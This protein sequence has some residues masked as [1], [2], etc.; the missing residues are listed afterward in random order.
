MAEPASK[1]KKLKQ[2]EETLNSPD[3]KKRQKL[4]AI[5]GVGRL[6]NV[7]RAKKNLTLSALRNIINPGQPKEVY[8]SALRV[9]LKLEAKGS[10]RETQLNFYE[11]ILITSGL[12]YNE[13]IGHKYSTGEPA[14]TKR[15]REFALKGLAKLGDVE[16]TF[17]RKKI[18]G[19]M[20]IIINYATPDEEMHM[21]M[22]RL[23][24]K[25]SPVNATNKEDFIKFY[26][27][28][29]TDSSYSLKARKLAIEGLEKL[30]EAE[31]LKSAS[32][33]KALDPPLRNAARK[34]LLSLLKKIPS[35]STAGLITPKKLRT[36]KRP[37][38]VA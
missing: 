13:E 17:G 6:G 10:E 31:S 5:R 28:I 22:I 24:L 12:E 21:G 9:M 23:S 15:A 2:Y 32:E 16:T 4:N 19:T 3:S 14:Y 37:G 26:K 25:L 35:R 34:A 20:R 38:M 11:D 30:G 7:F 27:D 1:A 29:L 8:Q 33:N 36:K 18:N